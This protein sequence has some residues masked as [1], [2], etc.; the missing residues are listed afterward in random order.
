MVFSKIEAIE[1]QRDNASI[2]IQPIRE[3]LVTLLREHGEQQ[4][5]GVVDRILTN[6]QSASHWKLS[7]DELRALNPDES[8]I[9]NVIIGTNPRSPNAEVLSAFSCI[10]VVVQSQGIHACYCLESE[11]EKSRRTI[12]RVGSHVGD[13]EEDGWGSIAELDDA[14]FELIEQAL[15]Y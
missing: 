6:S 10:K 9:T 2:V 12:G 1:R 7:V 5:I 15:A 4:R 8:V 3:R 14:F 13:I 11:P